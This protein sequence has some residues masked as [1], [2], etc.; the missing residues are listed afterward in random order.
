MRY[1]LL[2]IG[3]LC[4]TTNLWAT[5][6]TVEEVAKAKRYPVKYCAVTNTPAARKALIEELWAHDKSSETKLWPD[7]SVPFKIS[8]DPIRFQEHE[9]WQRNLVVTDINDPFFTF[10][11]A[12]GEG[13]KPVVVILPG[14]GYKRLGWS[15]EGT[16]IAKWLN[17]IGFSAAVLLYRAPDQ[18][19]AALCDTQR[20]IRLLRK[21]ASKYGI[22]KSLVGVIGFSAGANL[23]ARASTNWDKKFYSRIDDADDLSCRPDFQLLIYP[24]DLQYRKDPTTTRKRWKGLK[25]RPE[26]KVDAQTPPAFIAQSLDDFCKIETAIGYD[27]ALRRAGVKSIAWIYENGGHGY[28]ARSVG[29]QTDV[30]P[31]DAEKWLKSM[32]KGSSK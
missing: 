8:D 10:F 31:K 13:L 29:R 32:K 1:S 12:K 16:E 21:D 14:G 9:L 11:P 18:R 26:Y 24:W 5:F 25:L 2:V 7:G 17:S 22:D 20:A 27:Q 3:V 19:D 6:D 30:W 4:A 28:G 15:K 23:A